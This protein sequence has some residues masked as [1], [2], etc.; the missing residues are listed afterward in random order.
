MWQWGCKNQHLI[1]RIFKA[2]S[3]P[4]IKKLFWLLFAGSRGSDTRIRIMSVLRKK[5]RNRNQLS[6]ELCMDYKGIQHH[7]KVLEE[8]GLVK[9][10]ENHY[11]MECYVSELFIHNEIVFDE[12]VNK[13][14][15]HALLKL[16]EMRM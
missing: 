1:V 2:K 12:I 9:K 7:L 10:I 4:E 11:G 5:P 16:K 8:N 13:L 3:H 6:T 15:K 14:E